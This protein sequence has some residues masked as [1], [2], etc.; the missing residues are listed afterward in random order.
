MRLALGSV[1][2]AVAAF[3]HTSA[4]AGRIVFA[5]DFAS[6]SY[7][8][9]YVVSPS[10]KTTNLSR[11][12]AADTAP[13]GSPDGKRVAFAS[14]RGGHVHIFVVGSDGRGLHAV[15][16]AIAAIG[17]HDGS[18]TSVAWAP[19]GKRLAAIVSISGGQPALYVS[20]PWHV[21]ARNVAYASASWSLDGR[22]LAFATNGG[23]VRVA[24]A[25]GRA[26]WSVGGEGRSAWSQH[27]LLAVHQ[28]STT[29][30]TY[31]QRGKRLG[32]F[33]GIAF[34]WSPTGDV[35]A[36]DR[37]GTL[38]IR[39]AGTGKPMLRLKLATKARPDDD[40][41]VEWQSSTRI[42]LFDNGYAGYDVKTHR[43]FAIPV[44]ATIYSS[45]FSARGTIAAI[46]FGQPVD[47]LVRGTQ[48]V[49]TIPT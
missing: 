3:V 9:I 28:S 32:S 47:S 1:L 10:G 4:P 18:V 44:S 8:E 41:R 43:R 37:V 20:N 11:S 35:L 27:G 7:G 33:A 24:D 39:Q 12:P 45:V 17:P 38:E 13:A 14:V 40:S 15:S 29:I 36:S 6:K 31:D 16:P 22:R 42:R 21:V 5:A 2:A 19:D 48:T 26:M 46:R 23:L 30:A 34:A 49:A 25:S